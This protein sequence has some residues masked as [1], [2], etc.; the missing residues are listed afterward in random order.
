VR[1][2]KASLASEV[3]LRVV[4]ASEE[5]ARQLDPTHFAVASAMTDRSVLYR[6]SPIGE[7]SPFE[8]FV[9]NADSAT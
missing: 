2:E 7:A 3:S 8:S 6:T 5:T 9:T 4:H 1:A